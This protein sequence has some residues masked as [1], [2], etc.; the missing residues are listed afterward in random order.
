MKR[1]HIKI[2]GRVQGVFFR[3]HTFEAAVRLG[4][5]GWVRNMPNGG[6]E[7]TVEGDENKLDQFILFCKTG[8]SSARVDNI[9]I[10]RLEATGEFNKFEVKI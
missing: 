1:V 7:V 10:K 2:S 9:E 3:H 5:T 8:P 6:V 4:L